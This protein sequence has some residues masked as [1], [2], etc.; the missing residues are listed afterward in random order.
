MNV[1]ATPDFWV[2]VSF[3]GFIALLVY[4]KVPGLVAGAL[5]ERAEKIRKELDEAQRLREEAQA[6]LAEYQRKRR[7]AEKEV[8]GI[9]ALARDEAGRLSAETRT[10][11]AESLERRMKT[12]EAK[13]AQ[14]EAQ[15]LDEVRAAAAAAAV[16]A[17]E[18]VIAGSLTAK[19]QGELID[20]AIRDVKAR[21]N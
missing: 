8:E 18:T 1:F 19:A 16:A 5:D 7:D 20:A 2:A 3:V 12:T 21:L 14:A 4:F 13:I 11:L 6:L 9:L 10:A 17:A 15:A